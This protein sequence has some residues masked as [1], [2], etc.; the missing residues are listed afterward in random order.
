[1][2]DEEYP[3]EECFKKSFIKKVEK[4]RKGK[5]KTFKTLEELEEYLK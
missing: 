1:M 4:A 5:G 3:P 2:T